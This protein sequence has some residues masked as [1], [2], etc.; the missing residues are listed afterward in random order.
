MYSGEPTC[1]TYNFAGRAVSLGM[2]VSKSIRLQIVTHE[3]WKR[4]SSA[5]AFF[6]LVLLPMSIIE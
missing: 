2:S 5:Q 6:H 3:E 4:N 1:S